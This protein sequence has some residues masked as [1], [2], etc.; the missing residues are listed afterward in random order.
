M[1]KRLPYYLKLIRPV[2]LFIIFCTQFIFVLKATGFDVSSFI[3]PDFFLIVSA[4]ILTTA[5]GYIVNDLFDI[6]IDK[7]NKPLKQYIPQPIGFKEAKIFYFVLVIAGITTS[8]F[9][10]YSFLALVVAVN[11]LLYYY[12]QDLKKSILFGNLLVSF[13]SGM[14]VFTTTYACFN[15]S[16]NYYAMYS[17]LAFLMTMSRE[18]VKDVQDM[19]GDAAH[20]AKTL[21]IVLGPTASKWGASISTALVVAVLIFT[22]FLANKQGFWLGIGALIA[23]FIFTIQQLWLA[24]KPSEFG[25]ISFFLKIGMFAGILSVLLV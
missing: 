5:A 25:R 22:A 2:N 6:E 14:V 24:H 13:L 16:N 10:G 9:V 17:L 7:I 11:I 8:F 12:S 21:P 18:L 1:I 19:E 15:N 20:G 4:I 23:W 3:L